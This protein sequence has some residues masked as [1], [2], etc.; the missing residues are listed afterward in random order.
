MN[1]KKIKKIM[2][3]ILFDREKRFSYLCSLGLYNM[4]S[5]EKYLKK[6]YYAKMGYKL[7]LKSPKTLNEKIQWLKLNDRKP[8]YT[9]MVDKYEAKKFIADKVGDEYIIPTL[10]VWDDFNDI[11][12]DTLPNQFVLKTTHDSGGVVIVKDK[13]KI[14][15]AAAK[16]KIERSLKR[17]FY[18]ASREW[19]YKNVKP[20][21]IAEKF[22]VDE[23][24]WDLKDYKI[25]C[26]NGV[27]QYVE[28]DF[29]RAIQHKL[30]PY[31]LD[32][33]PLPFC[34]DSEN[35]WS[36]DIKKPDKL[37]EMLK[38]ATI[39]SENIPLLRVDLYYISGKIYVGELTFSPGAGYI[40]FKPMEYDK[41]LGEK[42]KLPL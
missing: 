4:M 7:D 10:G 36:A 19:P 37:D 9:T 18:L 21:I 38:I 34:D 35:D 20:R 31:S 3:A 24:G 32:W 25:F 5:D 11:D 6:R 41:I 16:E 27:P 42:L 40:A 22:L 23:S 2:R 29:N 39:L 13:S 33:K 17:N 14:D 8:I 1:I 30:N 26:F 12:F 28:V 15:M